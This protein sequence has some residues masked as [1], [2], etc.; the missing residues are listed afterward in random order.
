MQVYLSKEFVSPFEHHIDVVVDLL[1]VGY[2]I[3]NDLCILDN[4]SIIDL[5]L[6]NLSMS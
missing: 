1:V 4:P 3:I 5:G 2:F 6:V